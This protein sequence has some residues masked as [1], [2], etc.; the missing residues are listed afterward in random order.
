[1]RITQHKEGHKAPA[2]KE[3]I[4]D[5][6]GLSGPSIIPTNPITIGGAPAKHA[7]DYVL[8][9]AQAAH[10]PKPVSNFAMKPQSNINQPRKWT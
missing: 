6:T 8:E 7:S 5:V 4:G 1:M 10:S 2:S 3:I 9:S